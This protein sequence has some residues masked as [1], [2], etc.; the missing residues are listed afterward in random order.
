MNPN[1][2]L[3]EW[4]PLVAGLGLT[5]GGKPGGRNESEGASTDVGG[6]LGG[7]GWRVGGGE[8]VVGWFWR[9]C[10]RWN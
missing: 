2:R 9:S 7:W 1:H 5:V 10:S 6:M 4:W 8:G 3:T